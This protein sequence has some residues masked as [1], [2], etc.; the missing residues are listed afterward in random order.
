MEKY[1]STHPLVGFEPRTPKCTAPHATTALR[2]LLHFWCNERSYIHKGIQEAYNFASTHPWGSDEK[3]MITF[4]N[5]VH[6]LHRYGKMQ[7]F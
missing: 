6:Y 3:P 5:I 7:L 4:M 1:P 2:L